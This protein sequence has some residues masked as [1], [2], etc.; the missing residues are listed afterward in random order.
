MAMT[1][2][3]MVMQHDL[4]MTLT[5]S[6]VLHN[7]CSSCSSC[8]TRATRASHISI[9]VCPGL[10]NR[11]NFHFGMAQHGMAQH[12]VAQHIIAV[13]SKVQARACE[14]VADSS[15]TA[16]YLGNLRCRWVHSG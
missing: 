2:S 14:V 5:V 12:R 13:F 16:A 10:A 9:N 6:I 8:N 1:N 4:L 15:K 3:V 7:L 11:L